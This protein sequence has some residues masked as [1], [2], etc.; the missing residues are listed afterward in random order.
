MI[1]IRSELHQAV[2][3]L[4]LYGLFFPRLQLGW[5][6]QRGVVGTV[7]IG[8]KLGGS[9]NQSPSGPLCRA[10]G[11]LK[12]CASAVLLLGLFCFGGSENV[13]AYGAVCCTSCG[14]ITCL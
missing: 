4:L 10:L 7:L 12:L 14:F 9:R 11:S 6:W 13:C 8:E 1:P 2:C 5:F 3:L